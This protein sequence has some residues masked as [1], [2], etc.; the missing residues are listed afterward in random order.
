MNNQTEG[1]RGALTALQE[2]GA[3]ADGGRR[4]LKESRDGGSRKR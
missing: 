4:K 2:A 1:L 3:R